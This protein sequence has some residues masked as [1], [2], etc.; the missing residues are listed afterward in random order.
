MDAGEQAISR[1]AT[2]HMMTEANLTVR[3]PKGVLFVFAACWKQSRIPGKRRQ[4]S[5]QS[6][7]LATTPGWGFR[8]R[9]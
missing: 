6:L 4:L 2:I 1:T 8:S 3:S 7:E 5:H 9:W